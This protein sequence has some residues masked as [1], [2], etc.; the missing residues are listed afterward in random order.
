M[1]SGGYR[2]PEPFDAGVRF[3]CGPAQ[4]AFASLRFFGAAQRV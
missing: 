2:E 1:Y 3:A 4:G